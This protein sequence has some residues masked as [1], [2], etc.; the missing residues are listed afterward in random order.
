[1]GS[2]QSTPPAPPGLSFEERQLLQ[3]QNITLGQLNRMLSDE[4]LS[5]GQDQNLLRQL[6]GLY[7]VEDVAARPGDVTFSN[8]GGN[9]NLEALGSYARVDPF[10][11]RELTL[12]QAR[13]FKSKWSGFN[14]T[15]SGT[16]AALINNGFDPNTPVSQ[17][18]NSL[19]TDP[20]LALRFGFASRGAEIPATQKL[21]LN[22]NAV[23]DLRT[24]VAA[25]L[26]QQQRLSDLQSN[27]YEQGLLGLQSQLPQ[28]SKLNDLELQRRERALNGTLPVSQGLIDRKA[29]DFT[30]LKEGA[31]RRGIVIQGE[32]PSSATSQ[33]TA[34]NEL[35]GQFKRTYGLLEDAER[36]GELSSTSTPGIV[37]GGPGASTY[38]QTLNFAT[39]DSSSGLL[40]QY[41]QLS[42]LYGQAASPFQAQ[43]FNEYQGLLNSYSQGLA[44]KRGT[45]YGIG[46][47]ATLGGQ[48]GGG[49]GALVGGLLGLGASYI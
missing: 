10:T 42:Q 48:L 47:G 33:S 28:I 43:R 30:L 24:R 26:A 3:S 29:Q 5:K 37:Q 46:T 2:G 4:S 13:A 11:Q 12:E 49:Y 34:G 41:G 31:A 1:M 25:E 23:T 40:P 8:T 19:R 39:A 27:I 20:E 22:Q 21:T 9:G 36:R 15:G 14:S 7:N 18:V 45:L 38:G 6:S 17:A 32:D 35:V 44:N 16:A